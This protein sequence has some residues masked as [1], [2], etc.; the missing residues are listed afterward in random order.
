[1]ETIK[2]LDKNPAKTGK[3]QVKRD[4]KGRFKSGFSGNPN[5][6]L[7]GTKNFDTLLDE[8]FEKIVSEKK[9]ANLTNPE[10]EMA[11]RAVIEALKGNF[12]YFEYLMNKRYGKPKESM[13]ITS[14]DQSISPLPLED[15]APPEDLQAIEEFHEKLKANMRRRVLAK[16]DKDGD[17]E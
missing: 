15:D 2:T 13:D 7:P 3:M 11:V 4:E 14:Q 1:M 9:I 17:L 6:K 12:K 5:G 10:V 16:Y 8:A